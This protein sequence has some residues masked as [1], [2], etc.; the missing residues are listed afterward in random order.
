MSI[1]PLADRLLRLFRLLRFL[2]AIFPRIFLDLFEVVCAQ[3]GLEALA[4]VASVTCFGLGTHQ[5]DLSVQDR[6][7][8][9]VDLE[10]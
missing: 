8:R 4:R 1:E 2:V 9:S 7:L 10:E 6:S 3:R 5:P